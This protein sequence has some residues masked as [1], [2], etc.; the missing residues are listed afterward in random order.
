[1]VN[2]IHFNP[3]HEIILGQLQRGL[4]AN[5]KTQSIN[6]LKLNEKVEKNMKKGR[7]ERKIDKYR[8]VKE[9][10]RRGTEDN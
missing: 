3:K 4:C 8:K 2:S 5:F 1:M 6:I 9:G 7:E 10:D